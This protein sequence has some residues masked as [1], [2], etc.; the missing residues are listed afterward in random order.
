MGQH[1]RQGIIGRNPHICSLIEG[2]GAAQNQHAYC[3]HEQL[4]WKGTGGTQRTDNRFL[5]KG[6]DGSNQKPVD[7]G[8]QPDQLSFKD[9][10]SQKVEAVH[11]NEHDGKVHADL[12]ADGDH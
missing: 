4:D 6:S 7:K 10:L 12:V 3:H 11:D 2:A 9:Q 8:T 5:A 1:D